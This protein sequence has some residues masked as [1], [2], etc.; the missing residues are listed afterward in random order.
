M[1]AARLPNIVYILADDMG[2]GDLSCL[3]A[4][5]KIPTANMDRLAAGGMIFTDAHANSAVC[6]P[7]RYG[8]LTGRYCWRGRLQSG[9]L[10]GYDRMLI[11]RGRLTV[12]SL[13]RGHGYATACI[14]KWHLGLGW[15]LRAG[16]APVD[17]DGC[18]EDPGVDFTAPLSEGPHTVGFDQS[19]IIPSSLDIPPYCY[20]EDGRAAEPPTEH[21][22]ASPRPAFWRAGAIAPSFT[23]E[24]CLL[25]LTER[26]E[27]FIDRCAAGH[28]ARPFFLFFPT[29]SPHTPHVPREPF[30][31]KSRAGEYGDLVVETDWSVGRVVEALRRNRLLD[32]TLLIVTSDNGCHSEPIRLWERYG[33]LGNYIFRGQK[34]DAWDGGHRI[35]FIAHWPRRIRAGSV[36]A[37]TICLTDLLA[38]CAAVV[39][40]ELPD[41]AGE[42][43]SDLLPTLVGDAPGPGR[44]ATVHHSIRGKFAVRQ[45]PWK[46][47]CCRGSGGWSL[48]E[49]DVPADAPPA[50]LYHMDDDPRELVNLFADRP[51]VAARL[52]DVLDRFRR[53]GR[54]A[55][56]RA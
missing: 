44:P 45:G 16:A 28:P 23:H 36:C 3:N 30:R 22:E 38:T 32:E 18:E 56:S 1:P 51:D 25:H 27:A 43:S 7:T 20:V 40:A 54:S 37:E 31:G 5:S 34:S 21:I 13:L 29:P 15:A 52:L 9:V 48:P 26:A 17:R 19:C 6:T 11:E 24:G 39:G 41:D 49:E 47:V 50:Q 35:P 55:A 42:D 8:V 14:G 53:E 46:L 10:R 4:D 12:A 33:H 2:Y